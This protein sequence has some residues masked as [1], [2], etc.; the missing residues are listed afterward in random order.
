M[1][2]N[3]R[4]CAASLALLAI[5]LP[6]A[7]HA[8][9]LVSFDFT[10]GSTASS[11]S[12]I[13]STTSAY[14]AR[15]AEITAADDPGTTY[16]D[17]SDISSSSENAFMRAENTPN[18]SSP[19]GSVFYH[20]FS[21]TVAN[22]GAGETLNLTSFDFD[23]FATNIF[24]QFF[25]GVYS[26]AVGYTG[27]GDKLGT[28]NITGNA[29]NSFSLDLTSSNTVAG[30][31]FTGLTN[32]ETIEFRIFF[33]DSSTAQSRIHRVDNI[34]VNGTVV[35]EPGSYALLA[36]LSGLMFVMLRRRS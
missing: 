29:G 22:L 18:S 31:A 35:P 25:T 34:V 8:A 12:S 19:T 2:S 6:T 15:D 27:T 26:D 5:A 17:D 33:G 11:D 10:G 7:A 20:E 16:D 3:I 30:S 9:V 32:G 1:T 28:T 23:Y 24:G 4:T 14:D 13:Y 36:G 21:M